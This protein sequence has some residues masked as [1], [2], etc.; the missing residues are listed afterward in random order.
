[1]SRFDYSKDE[2]DVNR[3]IKFQEELLKKNTGSG[4][5][6]YRFLYNGIRESSKIT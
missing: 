1:M 3:V 5:I 6:A 4:C 2:R